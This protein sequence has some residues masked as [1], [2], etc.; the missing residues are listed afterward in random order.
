MKTNYMIKLGIVCTVA[1]IA[2]IISNCN[3][4]EKK[5]TQ[6]ENPGEL[7]NTNSQVE[8]GRYLVSICVCD[9]CHSP[10]IMTALGPM[11]DS[12]R[13]LSG[14]PADAVMPEINQ[15]ALSNWYLGEQDLTAWVG[16]WG[17][18]FP[19]NLTPD[20]STGTG[21]WTPELFIKIMRTGK[22]MGS[23]SGRPILPPMPWQN[24]GQMTDED[25]SA[26]FAFLKTLPAISNK[27][28]DPLPP[29]APRAGM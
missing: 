13:R 23:E 25:L 6:A 19:F 24:Y 3:P 4:P 18:S 10:K 14:H 17:V 29:S 21:A 16:P 7:M 1:G 9:D 26:V 20:T 2:A 22:H 12:S 15:K 27:V 28:P 11:A 8:R 5:E